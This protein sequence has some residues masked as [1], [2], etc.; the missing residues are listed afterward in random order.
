MTIRGVETPDKPLTWRGDN[1]IVYHDMRGFSH[2]T[3]DLVQ[4]IHRAHIRLTGHT[5]VPV[6]LLADDLLTLDF[7]VQVFASHPDVLDSI[8]ALAIVGNSFMLRHLVSMFISYHQPGYPVQR[9]DSR[10]EA[11]AW[12]ADEQKKTGEH[13]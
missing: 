11:E 5:A 9:F 10:G 4:F 8:S 13:Y 1:G 12:L 3:L 6:L 7:E 2:L